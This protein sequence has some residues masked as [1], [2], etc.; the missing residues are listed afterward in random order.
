MTYCDSCLDAAYDVVGYDED[1]PNAQEEFLDMVSGE[2][3]LVDH[4]CD[5]I[6]SD[7]EIPCKCRDHR[8]G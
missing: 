3:L 8:R 2:S 4:L 6:E 1:V 5:R 7:G